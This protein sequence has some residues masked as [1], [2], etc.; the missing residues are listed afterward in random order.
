MK[1]KVLFFGAA[2]LCLLVNVSAQTYELE[3]DNDI[4]VVG[5]SLDPKID[6][7]NEDTD[8]DAF[9]RF[10]DNGSASDALIGWDGSLQMLKI[11]H[12]SSI[13]GS[14]QI[15]INSDNHV[16][17]GEQN[18]LNAQLTIK[19][20]STTVSPQ[21]EL[22]ENNSGDYSRLRFSQF[23]LDGYWTTA[24]RAEV[25]NDPKLNFYYFDGTD[26]AN[27]VTIDGDDQRL[28]IRDVSSPLFDVHLKQSGTT[29]SNQGGIAF[30]DASQN[31]KWKIYN[32]GLNFSF[33]SEDLDIQTDPYS[34]DRKAYIERDGDYVIAPGQQPF[35]DGGT[36][37]RSKSKSFKDAIKKVNKLQTLSGK[38]RDNRP[39]LGFNVSDVE[40]VFPEAVSIAE[41]G[42]RGIIPD[43][44]AYLAIAAIQ[45]QQQLLEDKET[46]IIQLQ[47]Q[48][49]QLENRLL[50]IE[51][52]MA[53]SSPQ[54]NIN[55]STDNPT[56]LHLDAPFLEQNAPNPSNGITT[57]RY[58]L[59]NED[60]N[61]IL[62]IRNTSGQVISTTSLQGQGYGN[63]EVNIGEM[64]N[65]NYSYTL[66]IDGQVMDTKQMIVLK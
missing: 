19:N 54:Q 45:E 30:E 10:G 57:I 44:F 17:I 65:G 60:S 6:I 1:F 14:G 22:R 38:S 2:F 32:S 18:D 36:G 40:K 34:M 52:A 3:V 56:L 37:S 66:E 62:Q 35:T 61:A 12:G 5:S 24:A 16:G 55:I 59:P 21:L 15:N 43:K 49:S 27:V 13:S 50:Q 11:S 31:D 46:Q 8:G 41:E 47:D 58:Y 29:E 20:N 7:I 39:D 4:K 23:G 53:A 48:L 25:N 28:G 63:V 9:I 64:P 26:G 33:A 42:E 51:A